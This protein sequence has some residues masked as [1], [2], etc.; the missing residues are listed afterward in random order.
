M[1]AW[2]NFPSKVGCLQTIFTIVFFSVA[3][4][5][6]F[7]H[8]GDKLLGERK[9][10]V[11]KKRDECTSMGS[12]SRQYSKFVEAV[13]E[14]FGE[15]SPVIHSLNVVEQ[16][17]DQDLFSSDHAERIKRA[18]RYVPCCECIFSILEVK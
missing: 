16:Y 11:S 13:L 14:A 3:R 2:S 18:N 17:D 15:N 1:N 6:D 8:L 9:S 4:E 12:Q 10:Q 5:K 7:E